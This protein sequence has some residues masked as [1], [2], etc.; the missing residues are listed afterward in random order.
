MFCLLSAAWQDSYLYVFISV[1]MDFISYPFTEVW[2][3]YILL[4]IL[5]KMNG[6]GVPVFSV[7]PGFAA[8]EIQLVHSEHHR[9]IL[10]LPLFLIGILIDHPQIPHHAPAPEIVSVMGGCQIGK[11]VS[12]PILFR[13]YRLCCLFFQILQNFWIV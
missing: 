1:W 2:L 3:Y 8:V 12:F 4:Q 7:N 10:R 11:A 9:N 6:G 5:H 13:P